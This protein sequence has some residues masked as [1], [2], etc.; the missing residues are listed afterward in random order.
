MD[1]DQRKEETEKE[2]AGRQ[3]QLDALRK[4]IEI[5]VQSG[6]GIPAEEVLKRLEARFGKLTG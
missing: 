1:E 5:G 6:P 3:L 4:E 2:E